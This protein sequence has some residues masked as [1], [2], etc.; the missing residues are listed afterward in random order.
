[1]PKSNDLIWKIADFI[2]VK[3][4]LIYY[5][6]KFNKDVNSFDF[7]KLLLKLSIYDVNVEADLK[8]K[9]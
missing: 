3:H 5:S 1:M 4:C 2:F 8:I 7:S 9:E 6:V